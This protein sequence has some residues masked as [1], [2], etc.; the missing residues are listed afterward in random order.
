MIAILHKMQI[1]RIARAIG[2]ILAVAIVVLS[3]VP[4]ELRPVTPAP[5]HV[6]HFVTYLVTGF[7]FGL[8]YVRNHVFIG[9]LLVIFCALVEL[10]QVLVPGRHARLSDFVVDA[11]A[12]CFGLLAASLINQICARV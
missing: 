12:T 10:A 7:A 4:R 11:L 3:V 6:E 5:H 2:W 9:F 8:G 1:S